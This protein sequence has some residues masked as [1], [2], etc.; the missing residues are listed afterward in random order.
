MIPWQHTIMRSKMGN[1]GASRAD[2]P[3]VAGAEPLD[4]RNNIYKAW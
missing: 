2:A 3:C 1:N 4:Q